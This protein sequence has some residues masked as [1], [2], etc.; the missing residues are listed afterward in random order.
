M[1]FI[2]EGK[3]S[4]FS[5]LDIISFSGEFSPKIMKNSHQIGRRTI[6]ICEILL[7]LLCRYEEKWFLEESL[8]IIEMRI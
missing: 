6:E 3:K 5:S 1:D 2:L 8:A 4:E 7:K